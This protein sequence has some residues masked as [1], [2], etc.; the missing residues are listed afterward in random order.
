MTNFA[1]GGGGCID[2]LSETSFAAPRWAGF[3]ALINQQAMENGTAP[4]GGL[5]FINPAI[6]TLG[7]GS[8]YDSD[9]H[10]TTSGNNET[11]ILLGGF[12]AVPGYDLVTGW[13]T[14]N[15]QNLIDALAGPPATNF[16]FSATPAV[17]SINQG[18]SGTTTIAVIGVGGFEGSVNLSAAGLPSGLPSGVT[19]SWGTNPTVGTSVL[20]LTASS[21][22]TPGT[23]TL[24]I[25]GIS[26][27]LTATTTFAL[28]IQSPSFYLV[29]SPSTLILNPGTSNTSSI[30]VNP[31]S[32]FTVGEPYSR[33]L[34]ERPLRQQKRSIGTGEIPA[35]RRF[36]ACTG[37][38]G[39]QLF[40]QN[41]IDGCKH[42]QFG[43][44]QA[45]V[46]PFNPIQPACG[47]FIRGIAP[48]LSETFAAFFHLSQRQPPLHP[49]GTKPGANLLHRM[50]P[51]S[52]YVWMTR[53]K[54]N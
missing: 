18:S 38:Q 39:K 2:Y 30:T 40:R 12:N 31:S 4:S 10:D 35:I 52:G 19:A 25:N 50:P 28:T 6:Y 42:D 14:P 8:S 23:Y 13:G 41:A 22:A 45:T 48:F 3:M 24:T 36:V 33:V 46:L 1:C 32:G 5:G 27:N 47:N 20:T 43:G 29:A 11:S 9:L 49:D 26:G 51:W 53:R 54:R 15:G 21:S 44:G 7:A 17:L 16:G 34:L 37:A